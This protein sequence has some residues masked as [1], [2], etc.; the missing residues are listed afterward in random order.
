MDQVRLPTGGLAELR[1]AIE[2]TVGRDAVP[3]LREAGRRLAGD[4]EV[5]ISQQFGGP[6]PSIP[7]SKFWSKLDRYFSE[8]GWGRIEHEEL[9]GA[10]GAIVA[11]DWAEVDAS[12]QR[13]Y[14]CCHITTGLLAELLSRAVGEPVAVMQVHCTSRGD[15]VCRFLF[16]SP[17]S[18]LSVHQKLA[19]SQSLEEAISALT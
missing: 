19:N 15:P 9:N 5:A 6:L 2:D 13:Q 12:D 14:P 16:G 11:R 10:V 18:M 17:T 8:S 7:M 3:A 4:A 1:R